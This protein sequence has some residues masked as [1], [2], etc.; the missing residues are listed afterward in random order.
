MNQ[1]ETFIK[2]ITTTKKATV[3]AMIVNVEGSAYRKEGAWMVFT[4][5]A[6]SMGIISGGCLEDD[7]HKRAEGLFHT[8]KTEL[9]SYDMSSEDDL[10]WGRGAGCNGIV[11]I[12][13]RDID[14]SFRKTLTH[15]QQALHNKEPILY[16]QSTDNFMHYT[17]ATKTTD[18]NGFWDED[19]NWEWITADPFYNIA[20][21]RTFGESEYFIQLIWPKPDLYII[22]AGLDARPLAKFAHETGFN[23][24]LIDW[25][26]H[27]CQKKYFP[28]AA[29]IHHRNFPSLLNHIKFSSLDS[30]IIMT[31]DF[32]HDVNLLHI[33]KDKP[34]LYLGVLGSQQRTERL[35]GGETPKNIH[36]PVGLPIGA[37]GPEE[38]AISIV[39]ELI[40]IKKGKKK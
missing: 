29:S 11:Y 20:G 22:G 16:I 40:A 6:S 34:L 35:L 24:H 32:Q 2:Q 39:A 26:A 8:G 28:N 9:V 12:L 5:D 15:V 21:K 25:R 13:L 1:I 27:Y 33:L 23:V 31:H 7:L 17:F 3:L 18:T 38:I 19:S 30:V 36:T 37:D 14:D 10:S 4:E